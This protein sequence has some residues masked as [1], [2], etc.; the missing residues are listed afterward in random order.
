MLTQSLRFSQNINGF[1]PNSGRFYFSLLGI[2]LCWHV[3][4]IDYRILNCSVMQ[5]CKNAKTVDRLQSKNYEKSSNPFS[6]GLTIIH[7]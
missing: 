2:M 3:L 7:R 1:T 4:K 5:L 6:L